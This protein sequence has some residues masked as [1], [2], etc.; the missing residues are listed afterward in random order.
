[1]ETELATA[2]GNPR[3]QQPVGICVP[4]AMETETATAN[5]SLRRPVAME[6]EMRTANRNPCACSHGDINGNSQWE[7]ARSG[8]HGDRRG[9]SQW[10]ARENNSQ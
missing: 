2:N 7:P 1:M 5:G 10:G 4:I 3:G 8:R 9:D 6:T